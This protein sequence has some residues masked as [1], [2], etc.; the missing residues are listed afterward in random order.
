MHLPSSSTALALTLASLLGLLPALA[1]ATAQAADGRLLALSPAQLVQAG[2]T[3]ATPQPASGVAAASLLLHGSV[4]APPQATLLVS[5]PLAGVVQAVLVGPADGVRAGQTVAQLHSP[6][7]MSAQRD[8]LQARLL[9]A[10][11]AD[12]LQR[13]QQL[14]NDGIIADARLRETRFADQ[15]ARLVAD[16]RRQALRVAGLSD[17]RIQALVTTLQVQPGLTLAANAAGQVAEVLA[18][19]G[20]Q[21]DAGAPL[22]R[23]VRAV[24]LALALQATVAQAA[25]VRQGS[26]VQLLGCAATGRVRGVVPLLQGANQAVLVQVA[27][28]RASPCAQPNQ[29]ISAQVALAAAPAGALRVPVAALWL[30][31][32]A[33]RVFVRGSGGFRAQ[34][35]V[36]VS[37]DAGQ[38][39]LTGLAPDAAVV[40]SGVAALKG[41]WMGLGDA[42]APATPSTPA[43]AALR[44]PT[45]ASGAR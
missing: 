38:A 8:Y 40:V 29:A 35:V 32:A 12:R 18:Q 44:A 19:P 23:L 41:A 14:A 6:A 24:P 25:Q 31:G 13:D 15:Q 42:P 33:E 21:V 3:T 9:A 2:I 43:P 36:V 45:T 17:A 20:Q 28:D 30:D 39:V 10:Q 5:T 11:A 34:P 7:L 1:P 4:V 26:L 27:L 16:E 37:R 22:L